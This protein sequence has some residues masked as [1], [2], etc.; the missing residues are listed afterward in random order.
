MGSSNKRRICL[1]A[2]NS[3][4]NSWKKMT[5]TIGKL[6]VKSSMTIPCY[7][8]TIFN[9]MASISAKLWSYNR[10]QMYKK[11]LSFLFMFTFTFCFSVYIFFDVFWNT[12]TA[13]SFFLIFPSSCFE[14]FLNKGP[15][16]HWTDNSAET[17]VNYMNAKV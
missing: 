6:K 7:W 11:R 9:R 12:F 3:L 14:D 1:R 13:L 10:H 8:I 17:R 4:H 16:S 2:I 15:S 5:S